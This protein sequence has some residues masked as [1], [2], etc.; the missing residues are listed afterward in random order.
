MEYDKEMENLYRTNK[1]KFN[2][3]ARKWTELY[4]KA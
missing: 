4:A 1:E 2:E 3:E